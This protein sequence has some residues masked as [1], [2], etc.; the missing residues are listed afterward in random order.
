MSAFVDL[1][2]IAALDKLRWNISL[3]LSS[4]KVMETCMKKSCLHFTARLQFVT[5]YC[6]ERTSE[7][8]PV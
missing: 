4:L 8:S 5:T 7:H 2:L 6:L 3:A 1:L